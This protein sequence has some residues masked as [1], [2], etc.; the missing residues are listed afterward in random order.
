MYGGSLMSSYQWWLVALAAGLIMSG[1][2]CGG[3]GS[4][5]S[6]AG[7]AGSDAT[8]AD[9]PAESSTTCT[10][11]G[12]PG[13]RCDDAGCV[14]PT[15][16]PAN[17]GG[18]GSMGFVC[19]AGA[20]C[21]MSMCQNVAGSLSGLRWELPCTSAP[22]NFCNSVLD[23][24][25]ETV[26]TATLSGATGQ[27]YNVTL[28]FRGV[29]EQRTY[30]GYDGGEADGSSNP[31]SFIA[32]GLPPA[33]TDSSNIYELDISNPPQTYYLNSGTSGI[34]YVWLIDYLATI[35]MGAGA[36]VTLTANTVDQ[37]EIANHGPDGGPVLVPGVPPYPQPY[38]GQFVQMDVSAVVPAH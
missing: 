1:V 9:A 18:C 19:E 23:G 15:S 16:D 33:T 5:N 31:G 26:V 36:T 11:D 12:A 21:T 38:N 28:H 34:D 30:F 29:V 14:D 3:C 22:L 4:D 32:G 20:A 25:A 37:L 2:A 24:G 8:V 13:I 35:P 27:K 17:C 6:T 7:D 10:V